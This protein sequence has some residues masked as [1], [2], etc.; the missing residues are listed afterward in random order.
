[1]KASLRQKYL[2]NDAG[3]WRVV[4]SLR[5]GIQWRVSNLLSGIEDGPWDII[6]WRNMAIYLNL[7]SAA[8]VWDDLIKALR[9]GGLLIVG[10]AERPPSSSGLT[11]ISRCIYQ[12]Q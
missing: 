1:M 3:Q 11:C 7:K 9:P 5:R 6:L 8:R 2:L 12:F 4:D 10:K